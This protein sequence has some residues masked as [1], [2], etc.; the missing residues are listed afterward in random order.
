MLPLSEHPTNAPTSD[1]ETPET[2]FTMNTIHIDRSSFVAQDTYR[3]NQSFIEYNGHQKRI[4]TKDIQC[5]I[6]ATHNLSRM[7]SY[8]LQSY[9]TRKNG[10][11]NMFKLKQIMS[12]MNS[13]PLLQLYV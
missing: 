8:K 10:F 12:D 2:L 1:T 13:R 9:N 6:W 11:K 4:G 3:G 5:R 7:S